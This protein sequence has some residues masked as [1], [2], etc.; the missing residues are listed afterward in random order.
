MTTHIGNAWDGAIVRFPASA[1][2]FMKVCQRSTGLGGVVDITNGEYI[3]TNELDKYALGQQVM[4]IAMNLDDF[5]T[6]ED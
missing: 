4:I 3:P 1:R 5:T 6:D 2:F